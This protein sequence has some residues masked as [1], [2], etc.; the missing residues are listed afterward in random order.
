MAAIAAAALAA[1]DANSASVG[2]GRVVLT[3]TSSTG[4]TKAVLKWDNPGFTAS[5]VVNGKTFTLAGTKGTS[6]TAF[7]NEVTD[8]HG[9]CTGRVGD[10]PAASSY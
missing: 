1:G 2:P 3:C 10:I 8:G 7:A 9:I 6:L 5:V 4:K